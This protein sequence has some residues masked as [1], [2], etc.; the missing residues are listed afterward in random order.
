[1]VIRRAENSDFPAINLILKSEI[2][3]ITP[4]HI[5]KDIQ[6]KRLFIGIENENVIAILS[7]VPEME[8]NYIAMKRLLVAEGYHGK[9]YAQQMIDY[10]SKQVIGK[11]GCTPWVNN[12]AMCHMMEKLNFHLE[13][14][15]NEKWCYYVKQV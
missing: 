5:R 4:Y 9:G 14:I 7:L 8:Y 1:M 10:A 3:Y 15:F 11:V 12:A 13:Y 2:D 6:E